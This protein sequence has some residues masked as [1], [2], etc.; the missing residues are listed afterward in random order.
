MHW[1]HG[2][3]QCGFFTMPKAMECLLTC[4]PFA[5]IVRGLFPCNH[6]LIYPLSGPIHCSFAQEDQATV[7]VLL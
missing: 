2:K 7:V 6:G 3:Q 1:L 4:R 5:L